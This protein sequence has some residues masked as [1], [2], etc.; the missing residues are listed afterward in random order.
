MYLLIRV[1]GYFGA[2]PTIALVMLTAIIG[3]ALLRRQGAATLLRANERLNAGEVPAGE[4]I[5][6]VML[7]VSGALLLT[8]GFVT[9]AVGFALLVP[10]AR[11]WLVGRF[12]PQGAAAHRHSDVLEGEVISREEES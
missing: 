1:G 12:S 11:R 8:P 4:M 3:V 6:G 5:E 2:L 10:A 9:D 7:A